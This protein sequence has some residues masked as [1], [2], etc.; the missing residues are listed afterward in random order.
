MIFSTFRN[1][2]DNISLKIHITS[3][4]AD[5]QLFNLRS[6]YVTALY[7]AN[8]KITVKKLELGHIKTKPQSLWLMIIFCQFHWNKYPINFRWRHDWA[9][10]DWTRACHPCCHGTSVWPAPPLPAWLLPQRDWLCQP[11]ILQEDDFLCILICN[12]VDLL[13]NC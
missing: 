12:S 7:S 10:P 6:H 3:T 2:I 4:R 5:Q 8:T 13:I 9:V 1:I 11:W